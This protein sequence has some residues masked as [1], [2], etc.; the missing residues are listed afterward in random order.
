MYWWGVL[1]LT[2]DDKFLQVGCANICHDGA[3]LQVVWRRILVLRQGPGKTRRCP[4]CQDEYGYVHRT[5]KI[6][7]RNLAESDCC[8]KWLGGQNAS[9]VWRTGDK[10]HGGYGG[11]LDALRGGN[12]EEPGDR[13]RTDLVDLHQEEPVEYTLSPSA[14]AVLQVLQR[15]KYGSHCSWY[16]QAWMQ[17][18]VKQECPKIGIDP[19]CYLVS[20]RCCASAVDGYN[21]KGDKWDDHESCPCSEWCTAHVWGNCGS[22]KFYIVYLFICW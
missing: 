18:E 22:G 1:L 14:R 3:P 6:S 2:L 13:V 10:G 8:E 20:P 21:T 16:I 11:F 9:C 7:H 4:E 17:R 5:K 19:P 12:C 15:T